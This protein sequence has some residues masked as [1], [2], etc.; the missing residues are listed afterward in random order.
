M[1]GKDFL[2]SGL[3]S[4][5]ASLAMLAALGSNRERWQSAN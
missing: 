4:F 3:F 1:S 5:V 2:I